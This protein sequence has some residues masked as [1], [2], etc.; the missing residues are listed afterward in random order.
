[1][2]AHDSWHSLADSLHSASTTL[3]RGGAFLSAGNCQARNATP[4]AYTA[5]ACEYKP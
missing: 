3:L 2:D 4:S 1:M 5:D